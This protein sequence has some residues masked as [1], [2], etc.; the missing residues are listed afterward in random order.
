V[1]EILESFAR[2]ASDTRFADLP[3]IARKAGKERVLDALGCALGAVDCETSRV[4]K[5]VAAPAAGGNL[6]GRILGSRQVVAADDAAFIN[7][8][9]IRDLDFNDT[10][11]GGHPSD[12]LGALFALAPQA[13]ASGERLVT[14]AVIAYEIFIRLQMKAQLREKGWDQGFGISVGA[15][16]GMANLLGLDY[17]ATKHAIAITAVGNM[18]M[19]ATRAGQLSMWKGAATAYSVRAAVFG[20]RLAAAG[21]TG[22]EAP[23]TGRHGL[24]DL[25]SGPF[26]LPKFGKEAADFFIP[27]AKIKYWPVVYNMQA[28]VWAA[29]ELRRQVKPSELAGIDVQTYWSAW[30]ES[31]SE[32][33]KWNP[34]TRETADHS[35]P[36]ILAWVLKHG[37]IDHHAFVPESYLDQSL[38][39][40]MNIVTVGIDEQYEKE[41]PRVVSMRVT[42]KDKSG[43]SYEVK[44]VNPLGHEDNPVSAKDLAEKF[45][46]LAEPRIG[47]QRAAAALREW[48]RIE[49]APSV[50][51]ALDAVVVTEAAGTRAGGGKRT[52][53]KAAPTR[54]KASGA[55]RGRSTRKRGA[56]RR[57]SEFERS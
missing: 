56:G 19:R 37:M 3:E 12:A 8:C 23:F 28:L 4:G 42:A 32:P 51:S 24:F 54:G 57:R 13:G 55:A 5:A 49:K 40:L 1:D 45:T 7:S 15:A 2:F 9:M 35:L 6:G 20:V 30:H 39:P 34:T 17:E 47:R 22:P 52:A 21:M 53:G 25:I 43:R 26:E 31:G 16:A 48:E 18:P 50:A 11:P 33:A 44:V 27:R 46:R 29:L 36:Y 41:F 38:R 10:Y 14:A